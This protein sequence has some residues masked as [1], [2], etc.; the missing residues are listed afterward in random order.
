[1]SNL[2]VESVSRGRGPAAGPTRVYTAGARIRQR[3]ALRA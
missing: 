2:L 1:V 3:D